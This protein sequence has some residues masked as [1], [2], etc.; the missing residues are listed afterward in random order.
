[1]HPLAFGLSLFGHLPAWREGVCTTLDVYTLTCARHV[2]LDTGTGA[3]THTCQTGTQTTHTAL[4]RTQHMPQTHARAHSPT[5][6]HTHTTLAVEAAVGTLAVEA[7]VGTMAVEAA[8]CTTP[9]H[10]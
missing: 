1:M 7:A 3:R 5:R 6:T 4:P 10:M 2:V 8:V 9:P